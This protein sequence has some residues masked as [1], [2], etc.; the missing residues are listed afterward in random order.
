MIGATFGIVESYFINFMNILLL[1]E[2]IWV[3]MILLLSYH[4]G[5]AYGKDII[6]NCAEDHGRKPVGIY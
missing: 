6:K 4:E 3:M 2:E 5:G 1:I